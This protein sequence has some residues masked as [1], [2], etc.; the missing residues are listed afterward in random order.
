MNN[1]AAVCDDIGAVI[2]GIIRWIEIESPTSDTAAVNRMLDR[3]QQELAGLPITIERMPAATASPTFS[4][5]VRRAR[6][7]G[8]AS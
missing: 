7:N 3:V 1:A 5:S 6:A 2:E 4:S 8:P